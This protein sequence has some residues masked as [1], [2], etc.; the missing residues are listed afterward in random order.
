MHQ[1][2]PEIKERIVLAL[3]STEKPQCQ[4]VVGLTTGERCA[5][6]LIAEDVFGIQ[7]VGSGYLDS[8][9]MV[10]SL[11]LSFSPG[12]ES[13]RMSMLVTL[14]Q[15]EAQLVHWNDAHGLSF[16]EIARKVK[17]WNGEREECEHY[18]ALMSQPWFWSG[19]KCYPPGTAPEAVVE[20]VAT[21][22]A[23]FKNFKNTF[24]NKLLTV[25]SFE[26]FRARLK[27]SSVLGASHVSAPLIE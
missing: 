1:L 14:G 18:S 17:D 26:Q 20:E 2:D 13:E 22:P 19:Q 5:V 6:G 11:P 7:L 27:E 16:D 9:P 23:Y 12:Q 24:G 15:L 21:M 4:N 3:L 25:E 8:V 10:V